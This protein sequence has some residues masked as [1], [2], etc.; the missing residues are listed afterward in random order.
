VDREGQQEEA[1]RREPERVV[2]EGAAVRPR[3][4]RAELR[5]GRRGGGAR[6]PV[7]ILLRAVRQAS[8]VGRRG[9]PAWAWMKSALFGFSPN[10]PSLRSIISVTGAVGRAQCLSGA[11]NPVAVWHTGT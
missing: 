2:G 1:G 7:A 11:M 3:G 9:S 5:R 8:A 6:E 10:T 4:V